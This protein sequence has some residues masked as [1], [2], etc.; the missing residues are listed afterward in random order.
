[1]VAE[2]QSKSV[3]PAT[4]PTALG[5]GRAFIIGINEYLNPRWRLQ[6]AVND[7]EAIAR[8]LSGVHHYDVTLLRDGEATLSA[9]LQL[10]KDLKEGPSRVLPNDRVVIYFGG[11]GLGYSDRGEFKGA[12]LPQ[13]VQLG[14]PTSYLDMQRLFQELES[15]EC[16]HLLMVL[17]CCF[18]G[19]ARAAMRDVVDTP[20]LYKEQYYRFLRDRA[21][22]LL[23]SAGESQRASDGDARLGRRGEATGGHS[24]FAAALLRALESDAADCRTTDREPDYI[25]IAPELYQ[26]VREKVEQ[27]SF[28]QTPGLWPL[29]KHGTGEYFFLLPDFDESRLE[30]APE[31]DRAKNPYRGAAPYLDAHAEIFFGRHALAHE[32]EDLVAGPL[33]V[34]VGPSGS[35]KTSLVQAGLVPRLRKQK[36]PRQWQVGNLDLRGQ[37]DHADALPVLPLPDLPPHID[38]AASLDTQLRAWDEAHSETLLLLIVDHCEEFFIRGR[39][40]QA[41]QFFAE[42]SSALTTYKSFL[43]ILLVVRADMEPRLKELVD[44]KHWTADARC[45]VPPMQQ[46][47]LRD[48]I[49][50]PAKKA[51]L[52]FD[53]EDSVD[54]LINEFGPALPWIS[55][56]LD[57]LYTRTWQRWQAGDRSRVLKYEDYLDMGSISGVLSRQAEAVY[58]ELG[59]PDTSG[60]H[61]SAGSAPAHPGDKQ[62]IMQRVLLRM[63]DTDDA[64]AE[65]GV[66]LVPLSELDYDTN[67]DVRQVV[68]RLAEAHLIVIG[69]HRTGEAY[70]TPAHPKLIQGWQRLREWQAAAETVLPLRLHR[71]LT[72]DA[73]DWERTPPGRPEW[74]LW[75][76][77]SNLTGVEQTLNVAPER[78]NRL[79]RDFARASVELRERNERARKR[80]LMALVGLT[81][82]SLIAAVIAWLYAG[83]AQLQTRRAQQEARV[84]RVG[85][86]TTQARTRLDE[87]PVQTLLLTL[88]AL[89]T[90]MSVGEPPLPAAQEL[91]YEGLSRVGGRG[92]SGS[93]DYINSMAI[94]SDNRWLAASSSDGVLLW[95]LT[96]RDPAAAPIV[97]TA[98]FGM[99]PQITLSPGNKWL[100]V[101][102]S[103]GVF[104]WNLKV[105]PT[106]QGPVLLTSDEP[107]GGVVFSPD[108]RWLS[109]YYEKSD[110]QFS[111][112]SELILWDLS[113]AN[114][115]ANG[116]TL[117]VAERVV[118]FPSATASVE[119]GLPMPTG[120]VEPGLPNATATMA[121]NLPIATSTD[122]W[123]LPTAAS[124]HSVE[125]DP[126]TYPTSAPY[127]PT[128]YLPPSTEPVP[129]PPHNE[130]A[131]GFTPSD[132]DL[133]MYNTFGQLPGAA[134]FSLDGRW[135]AA[136]APSGMFASASPSGIVLWDLNNLDLPAVRLSDT[137]PIAVSANGRWAVTPPVDGYVQIWD[138]A[139]LGTNA[140]PRRFG[141]PG[142]APL[143][144][145][146]GISS[147]G[148]W[149]AMTSVLMT[150]YSTVPVEKLYV[151]DLTAS[152]P[153]S[154]GRVLID[155]NFDEEH[156]IQSLSFSPGNQWLVVERLHSSLTPFNLDPR[157]GEATR[158]N[159]EGSEMLMGF[160]SKDRWMAGATA[161]GAPIL[162]WDMNT[163]RTYVLDGEGI[164]SNYE[165][166]GNQGFVFYGNGAVFS[167]DERWVAIG[168]T[169]GMIR[170]W[171]LTMPLSPAQPFHLYPNSAAVQEAGQ[172]AG[173]SLNHA[174]NELLTIALD[175]TLRFWDLDSENPTLNPRTVTPETGH[176]EPTSQET[177]EVTYSYNLSPDGRWLVTDHHTRLVLRDLTA[178]D[179][180]AGM[181]T[182]LTYS[183]PMEYYA[184]ILTFS[185]DS[186]WLLA[187]EPG[188]D[189]FLWD[190]TAA[191]PVATGRILSRQ[192]PYY[193]GD[194]VNKLSVAQ[195]VAIKTDGQTINIVDL[196]S[197]EP[198]SSPL[199]LRSKSWG[200]LQVASPDGRWLASRRSAAGEVPGS[201]S[202]IELR[203]LKSA[204]RDLSQPTFT[205][206]T[207]TGGVPLSFS[208]DGRWLSDGRHLWDLNSTAPGA[209]VRRLAT[210]E[211]GIPRGVTFSPGGKWLAIISPH[212]AARGIRLYD[213]RSMDS[214]TEPLTIFPGQEATRIM[215]SADERW[216]IMVPQMGKAALLWSLEIRELIEIA[217]Q[218]AGRNLT[219]REW[220]QYGGFGEYR[221]TCPGLPSGEHLLT[222]GD[223]I[224]EVVHDTT[225][226]PEVVLP[227]P[228]QAVILPLPSPGP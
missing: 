116:R 48:A 108:D 54:A 111:D 106:P 134:H 37:F 202:I 51:V 161:D 179:P 218:A 192:V 100:L 66:R 29:P 49:V 42:L 36:L 112:R 99:L 139:N 114:F 6:N 217:C 70:A 91:L 128:P 44:E 12:L 77:G 137:G 60:G 75:A 209:S 117:P 206:T 135:M 11:H 171:D 5:R 73:S 197:A 205:L 62:A 180:R 7:A 16:R 200:D 225:P 119:P 39:D 8:A 184:T 193:R 87:L 102:G 107:E 152:E 165:L 115:E 154:S 169:T 95:D 3:Q 149:L 71:K 104:L 204:P 23:T 198:F 219:A 207:Q 159:A 212:G 101:A 13:D 98:T 55:R 28:A 227:L 110:D 211:G 30:A 140:T 50:E 178:T 45:V 195:R 131:P 224:R 57:E 61:V 85:Q 15:L 181:R 155:K 214:A 210:L 121:A 141:G 123:S 68:E 2:Q 203:D 24:P 82:A 176:E 151:W 172:L 222:P 194:I 199:V 120:S 90:T 163:G 86:L 143:S 74:L 201:A 223:T 25:V 64:S 186:H 133:F 138:L 145:R 156:P 146:I 150:E 43:R 40:L 1:M 132:P 26:Y 127:L 17:D 21:W 160:S 208:N 215:F 142:V 185:S 168:D 56:T 216:L 78:L 27:F 34:L 213:M 88:E 58:V 46:D 9:L 92:L 228:S 191:D 41:Q 76:G 10:L 113:T 175:S 147:D 187:V 96:S 105:G 81:I 59:E 83:E 35:G 38:P 69:R 47:D 109:L 122:P 167:D 188:S 177:P 94:S 129:V 4:S 157:P 153:A 190:L 33:T 162:L 125:G 136:Y 63:I 20:P 221:K 148:R 166:R 189:A 173:L 220:E 72:R 170:V 84:A 118:V 65:Y 14:V 226:T 103:S 19:L 174:N 80:R 32:L 52:F 144:S 67:K 79:E 31:L 22:Q 158:M 182:L 124:P 97:L 53:P 130:G 164:L 89:T 183:R 126:N 93:T 196:T 18:A